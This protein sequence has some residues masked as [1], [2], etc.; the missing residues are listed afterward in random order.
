MQDVLGDIKPVIEDILL[1]E[2]PGSILEISGFNGCFAELVSNCKKRVLLQDKKSGITEID[3]IDVSGVE[4]HFESCLYDNIFGTDHLTQISNIKRYD[5]IVVF[6]IFE[7]SI[8]DDAKEFLEKLLKKVNMSV[9]VFTPLYPYDPDPE[10]GLS[11]VRVYHPVFFLGLEFSYKL[12]ET[13]DGTLQTYSFFPKVKYD[14]LKCD[15]LPEPTP[16]PVTCKKLKIAYVIPHFVLTGSMKA[17]LQQMKE[18]AKGG[19]TVIAYYRS[20]EKSNAI[21][22]WSD[23]SNDDISGQTVIPEGE[24]YLDHIKDVDIIVLGWMY[25][26]PEFRHSTIP[27]VLWEQGSE[28]FFGDYKEMQGSE[29]LDRLALHTVFRIPVHLLAVSTPVQTVLENVYNRLS[30][31]FPLNIDTDFYYPLKEKKNEIPV[32]LLVGK[33]TLPFKGFDVALYALELVKSAGHKFK[34]VWA[35]PVEFSFPGITIEFEKHVEPTQEKLAELFRS[36]DIYLS[37][38][39]YESFSLPPL[40]AMASGTAVVATDNGGINTY[41]KP[42]VNCL[43]CEQGD[44]NSI[45][46]ALQYL[47][48]NPEVREL[49]AIEGRKT[50]LEYSVGNTT[51]M[52]EQCFYRILNN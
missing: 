14:V 29:S 44:L 37:T 2:K 5:I 52:L 9:L 26:V 41:A 17:M 50:A 19:H 22:D 34:L 8:A 4:N 1:N 27:V 36:A 33:P 21:P 40:E 18:L 35:T 24:S 11:A 47:L 31:L 32:I 10:V 7:N 46:V 42:G 49:L 30:Q 48:Q 43:L 20:N 3:R 12:L 13:D 38:S 39:L 23:L 51:H 28:M 25:Q 6:H 45:A 15:M 16:S